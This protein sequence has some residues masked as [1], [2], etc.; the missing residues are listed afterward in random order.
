MEVETEKPR[1][2]KPT[3]LQVLEA[4]SWQA[5]LI[6]SGIAIFGSLQLPELLN[7]GEEGVLIHCNIESLASGMFTLRIE[8]DYKNEDGEAKVS[9]LPF[10]YAGN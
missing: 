1:N 3:W 10:W 7:R 5:E 6:V 4:K 9:L 8:Y 2:E